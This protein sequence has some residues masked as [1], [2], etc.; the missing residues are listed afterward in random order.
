MEFTGTM[1]GLPP[2][3]RGRKASGWW[4][5]FV[6]FLAAIL[7]Y[8]DRQILSLLVDPIRAGLNLSDVQLGILHGTAFAVLYAAFGLP[9]GRLADLMNRRNLILVGVMI[10][11]TA[12]VACA[13]ARSFE[14][15]LVARLFVGLG[16][17]ALAPAALSMISDLF[18]AE[19]RG[20]AIGTFALGIVAGAG[21][22]I[23][24]GGTLL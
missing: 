19:R 10:W 14:E 21:V 5:V 2:E 4:A 12:T 16:E 1:D 13:W 18:P 11:S 17:A 8:T 22:A 6:F 15:L 9:L 3:M 23:G 24:V 7:S 20:V